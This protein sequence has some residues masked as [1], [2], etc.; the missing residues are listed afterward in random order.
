M[1]YEIH[2][3][4]NKTFLFPP[5]LEDLVPQDHPARFIREFVDA[6]ELDELGFKRRENFVDGRPNYSPEL[7]LSI[8]IYGYYFQ[9]LSS[10]KLEKACM[11]NIA[12]IW[13][14]G[15]NYPDHN[16][17]WRFFKHNKSA[18]TNVFKNSV[19]IASEMDLIGMVLHAVDGTKIQANVSRKK[20]AASQ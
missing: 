12:L 3:Q 17:I 20:S 8:W 11:E 2:P 16:T 19:R 1:S 13:L 14:T 10:R 5:N 7:L 4:Y 15:M 9:I 6:L 18:I